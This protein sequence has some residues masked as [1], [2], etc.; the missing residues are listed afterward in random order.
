MSRSALYPVLNCTFAI[1]IAKLSALLAEFELIQIL[2]HIKLNLSRVGV[3]L[4]VLHSCFL[5]AVEGSRVLR[6]VFAYCQLRIYTVCSTSQSQ[7]SS[8]IQFS[9]SAYYPFSV[10]KIQGEGAAKIARGLSDRAGA[11]TLRHKGFMTY[12]IRM[13]PQLASAV[14]KAVVT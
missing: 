5:L 2:I 11:L 3:A 8:I 10:T 14:C 7:L 6:S 13:F 9:M 4:A 1:A 12:I